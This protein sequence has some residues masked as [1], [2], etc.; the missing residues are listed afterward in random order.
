MAKAPNGQRHPV[1]DVPT[2]LVIPSE[3]CR[4]GR[5]LAKL[6]EDVKLLQQEIKNVEKGTKFQRF[7]LEIHCSRSGMSFCHR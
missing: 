6:I 4:D 1:V 5:Y 2:S 3:V 7:K